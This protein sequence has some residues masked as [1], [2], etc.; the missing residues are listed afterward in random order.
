MDDD[1]IGVARK[2]ATPYPTIADLADPIAAYPNPF[3]FGLNRRLPNLQTV[4]ERF[5]PERVHGKLPTV[6]V[7]W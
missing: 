1:E 7:Q 6:V 5:A 4:N 3:G 2:H